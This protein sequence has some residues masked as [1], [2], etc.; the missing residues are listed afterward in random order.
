LLRR[1]RDLT[2]IQ[3]HRIVDFMPRVGWNKGQAARWMVKRMAPDASERPRRRALRRRR[4][5]RRVVF[6]ALRGK[7]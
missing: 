3:G 4:T 2:A 5:H 1:R 6:T 7:R